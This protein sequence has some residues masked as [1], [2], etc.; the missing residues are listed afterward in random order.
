MLFP[1]YI[2]Y[3]NQNDE[4]L[5]LDWILSTIDNLV[6]EVANFVTLNTIKYADPIQWNITTQYEKNTVVIDPVT[7]SAYISTKPVPSGV[8]LNNEDYWNIIFTLDV[9]SANKNITLRDDANNMLATF[10]SEVDE[11]L[12]WQGT[13]YIVTRAIGVGQAYVVGYNIDRYTVE[14]FLKEYIRNV[15]SLIGSLSDLTT[16]EKSTLVGAINE[17]DSIIDT[18][19]GNLSDLTADIGDLDD[20]STTDKDSIVDAINELVLTLNNR[21]GDLD[22]LVTTDKD[23]AVDAINELA[24]EIISLKEAKNVYNLVSNMV[25]DTSLSAGDTVATLGYHAAGVGGCIY[26]VSSTTGTGAITL[27]NGLFAIPKIKGVINLSQT[28][29]V[30]NTDATPYILEAISLLDGNG[31]VKLDSNITIKTPLSINLLSGQNITID[32][33]NFTIGTTLTSGNAITING[34]GNSLNTFNIKNCNIVC[35]STNNTTTAIYLVDIWQTLKLSSIENVTI[36]DFKTGIRCTDSKLV[37]LENVSFWCGATDSTAI[38]FEAID[39]LSTGLIYHFGQINASG[40]GN[41]LDSIKFAIPLGKEVGFE[42]SNVDFYAATHSNIDAEMSGD[43]ID[44]W[45]TECQFDGPTPNPILYINTE[46]S[47]LVN[48]NIHNN[49]CTAPTN[50]IAC[51]AP[52][53][54]LADAIQISN[55]YINGSSDT[56]ISINLHNGSAIISNNRLINCK[57][58]NSGL[59]NTDN[60][61]IATITGN[62]IVQTTGSTYSGIRLSASNAAAIVTD[63]YI[64]S[65][66]STAIV[67]SAATAI[68]DNNIFGV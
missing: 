31:I 40:S 8:G 6:N 12:L 65:S 22:D 60:L 24:G 63:N 23:S 28:G 51:Y 14:M 11:W 58:G 53:L 38:L 30:E 68:T 7:G 35:S 10:E 13:L 39:R 25:A 45:I 48:I 33:Q 26:I 16:T 18:I 64:N 29:Y 2:K 37:I 9:I 46:A 20:L 5:N 21:L 62:Q 67:N 32:G 43:W 3:P 50:F 59:I 54:A 36:I 15:V 61:R 52:N 42:I 66:A 57:S 34:N 47:R 19:S 49:Y 1:W 27:N 17:L 55:N 4:I 56:T 44:T 41:V